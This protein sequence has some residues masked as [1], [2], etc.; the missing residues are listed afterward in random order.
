[1]ETYPNQRKYDALVKISQDNFKAFLYDCDGTLADN[2]PAHTETYI[3]VAAAHGVEIDG[4]IIDEFAGLPIVNVVE[5]INHRYQ[6]NFNPEEFKAQKYKIFLEEYIEKTQPIDYVVNHLKN[7]AGKV[8]IAVVSGSSRIVVEQTMK[9]LG[10]NHL[11]EVMVC[12]GETP[13]GKP[14]PDPFLKAAELLGVEP[15][16]CLVFEDGNPGTQA[17]DAAGMRWVR[18]DKL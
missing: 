14:Y 6:T 18:I 12:A 17:A 13:N 10:I 3:R 8:R 11:I 9:I 7:H 4:A 5:Q 1:M 16:D 15:Q 2:M